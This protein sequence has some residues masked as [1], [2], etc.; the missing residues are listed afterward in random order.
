MYYGGGSPGGVYV[1]C[2]GL[3]NI[4]YVFRALS[5]LY[6]YIVDTF[7]LLAVL[8]PFAP[9]YFARFHFLHVIVP[10]ALRCFVCASIVR[11]L[12]FYLLS[13]D[14]LVLQCK[15]LLLIKP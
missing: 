14:L 12:V 3:S 1:Y 9:L 4:V 7:N 10:L 15:Y 11:G 2:I 5:R 8:I 13:C 6:I